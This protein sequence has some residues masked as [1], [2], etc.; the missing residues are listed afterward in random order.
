LYL[1]DAEDLQDLLAPPGNTGGVG[2]ISGVY[3]WMSKVYQAQICNYG[4]RTMYDFMVP[5][6]GAFLIEAMQSAHANA[7]EIEKPIPF[8]LRP[9]QGIWRY[10]CRTSI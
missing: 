5:E 10:R 6:P 9:D 3:Q 2:H 8:T 1:D 4:L 7:V